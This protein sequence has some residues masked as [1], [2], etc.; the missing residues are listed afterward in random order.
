MRIAR[1]SDTFVGEISG[2]DLSQAIAEMDFA[3]ISDAF[4]DHSI[5]LFR[6]QTLSKRE[7][8]DFSSHFG[9]FLIHVLSQYLASDVPQ[10]MRLSNTDEKGIRADFRNGAEAWHSDLSF[11]AVPSLATIL[12]GE[13]IPDIGGDTLFCDCYAAYGALSEGMKDR[14]AGMA[15]VHSFH[16]YQR[17][18]F[19]ERPLTEEQKRS[20]PDVAHPV[21][22]THPVSGRKSLFIG[23]DVI[24]HVVG[25]EKRKGKKIMDD[26]LEHA[27]QERFV[28]RHRWRKGDLIA[29]DNRCTLHRA[30]EFDNDKYERT[31][32][33]TSIK[34][35]VPF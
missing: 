20:T 6:D 28:Y 5:L 3:A 22:R 17:R 9:E 23:A 1:I 24:S 10:V 34:G 14:L 27:T 31:L 8:I 33:R 4:L 30:T 35:D 29:Y 15:A 11:M 16:R 2:V 7:L 25:I 32:L 26:L 21:V 13:A 12:Y 19:P 18:R